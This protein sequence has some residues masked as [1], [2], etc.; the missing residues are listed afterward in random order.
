MKH[1]ASFPSFTLPDPKPSVLY[2]P[3]KLFVSYPHMSETFSSSYC[4]PLKCHFLINSIS[5]RP[6]QGILK[7]QF[8]TDKTQHFECGP[9]VDAFIHPGEYPLFP[10]H[11]T[12]DFLMT[13]LSLF[14]LLP[15]RLS[16]FQ[17]HV[18]ESIQALPESIAY[19]GAGWLQVP[20]SC[21]AQ[22]FQRQQLLNFIE[23][24]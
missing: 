2:N 16:P 6:R 12:A 1:T 20:G 9:A 17:D 4:I 5:T 24:Q 13:C 7:S 11:I 21:R 15:Q 8:W 18:M 14:F 3:Y 22:F 19:D 10:S 23:S